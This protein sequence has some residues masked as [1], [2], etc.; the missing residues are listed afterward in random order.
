M[1]KVKRGFR[2]NRLPDGG[3]Q[4]SVNKNPGG[5]ISSSI[6][7]QNQ[8]NIA[9]NTGPAAGGPEFYQSGSSGSSSSSISKEILLPPIMDFL[10]ESRARHESNRAAFGQAVAQLAATVPFA[11]PQGTD[12]FPGFEKG[13]LAD[14]L[15]GMITGEG[16]AH[17]GQFNEGLRRPGKTTIPISGMA[18]P[19]P[20]LQ[21]EYGQLL[22]LA[23]QL[24]DL[25]KLLQTSQS[26]S[27]S[28]SS[29]T[30]Q[31]QPTGASGPDL[32]Q[33]IMAMLAGQQ[34]QQPVGYQNYLDFDTGDIISGQPTP[35]G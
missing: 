4:K 17:A 33:I 22:P 15:L 6:M 28:G 31:V 27:S 29:S 11:A 14:S 19:M 21:Q 26:G 1:I 23:T 9:A 20:S 32:S 30:D 2:Y 13:G 10:A 34:G 18:A 24:L 16:T 3:T 35:G 8:A 12:I 7:K 25:A 5:S